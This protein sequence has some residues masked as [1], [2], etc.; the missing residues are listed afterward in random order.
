MAAKKT[1]GRMVSS[2][3]LN[4][5]DLALGGQPVLTV[6]KGTDNTDGDAEFIY[7][8]GAAN[9][10]VGS[11]VT[12]DHLGQTTL[13]VADASGP[14][15]VAM[16]VVDAVTKYGWY[17]I[18]GVV[19]VDVVANSAA[20]VAGGKNPGFETTA[21]K[22]GDGRAAGDEIHNFF[23]RVATVAAALALCQID[24]PYVN[25]FTGA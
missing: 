6:V 5:V 12:Y 7:L 13:I 17:C 16:G 15:A 20:A 22:V 14:V 4:R 9:T 10:I 3:P 25:N 2:G 21:G 24:H 23:Q 1:G 18:K 11:V 19:P 8:Q